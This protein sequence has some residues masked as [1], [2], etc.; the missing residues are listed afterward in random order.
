MNQDKTKDPNTDRAETAISPL[1]IAVVM[2]EYCRRMNFSATG[3]MM[4][5][6]GNSYAIIS[7][8]TKNIYCGEY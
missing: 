6:Y 5:R 4:K 2:T 7:D 1:K 3:S 8:I